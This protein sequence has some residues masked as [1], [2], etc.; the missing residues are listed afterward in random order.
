MRFF[1]FTRHN[2]IFCILLNF[3]EWK[4]ALREQIISSTSKT[5]SQLYHTSRLLTKPFRKIQSKYTACFFLSV[6]SLTIQISFF[7]YIMFSILTTTSC[8]LQ[9]T[10]HCSPAH[11]TCTRSLQPIGWRRVTS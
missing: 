3:G 5:L 1:S 6:N 7:N 4:T 9:W 2:G 10:L 8:C 11:E